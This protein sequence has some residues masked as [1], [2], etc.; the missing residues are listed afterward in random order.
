LRDEEHEVSAAIGLP[1][2]AYTR[3]ILAGWRGRHAETTQMI[4]SGEQDAI[5]RGEGR[6]I[7]AGDCA[8]AVLYNGL[9]TPPRGRRGPVR[10]GVRP[11][12]VKTPGDRA[13]ASSD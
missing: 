5:A 13:R 12:H 9:G 7:G 6:T 11:A 2:V 3:M 1:D 10:P 8:A 4:A